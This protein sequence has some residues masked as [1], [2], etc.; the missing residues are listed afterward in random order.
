[1]SD[2]CVGEIRM[3]AGRYE[4]DGWA[5]CDGRHLKIS[6]YQVLFSLIVTTYGGDGRLDFALPDLRSRVPL[7][8]GTSASKISYALGKAGGEE[9]V[10]LLTSQTPAHTHGLTATSVQATTGNPA[11]QLM[12]QTVNTAGGTNQDAAYLQLGAST[13]TRLELNS[14]MVTSTGGNL[15]HNNLMPCAGIHFIIALQGIYPSFS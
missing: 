5:F 8:Q 2:Q 10:T 4:P 7:G 9:G 11:G 14:A 1:M 12:A 3:F 15:P 6:D 13:L